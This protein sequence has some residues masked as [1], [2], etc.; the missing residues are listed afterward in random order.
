MSTARFLAVGHFSRRDAARISEAAA[1]AAGTAEF[2]SSVEDRRSWSS[3]YDLAGILLDAGTPGAEHVALESRAES[4]RMTLPILAVAERVSDLKFGEAFAWGADDL[5]QLD[6]RRGLVTRMRSLPREPL[7]VPE[8]K[9][10]HVLIADADRARRIAIGRV[11]RNAGYS[12][13]F[14]VATPDVA[15][16][17]AES[18]VTVVLLNTELEPEPK[19]LI[20]QAERSGSEAMWIVSCAPR[21]MR[22]Y[23]A[24]L[25][26]LRSATATDGFAPPENMLFV[27]NELCSSKRVEQRASARL[28][29]GT[30][31]WF[32]PAGHEE[33]DFGFCYN[34]SEGGLYVRTL[35]PPE[36]EQVWLELVPP[37]TERRVRLVGQVA[38]RR[39]FG[40]S[41]YATVPPGVG[42]Q[43]VDGAR[44]DLESWKAGYQAF[45]QDLS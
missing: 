30:T 6:Q 16:I 1:E 40:R 34:V 38:W 4:E 42:V 3:R 45:L 27:S 33:D 35:A 41:D 22:R 39:P 12:I 26:G 18:Q 43:I 5:V 28:L 24:M 8:A 10:G 36:G 17:V 2:V 15:R 20:E 44:A 23:R 37:R 31:V 7:P 11:L 13:S 19:T 32:R 9:R 25:A 29:Y 14:A 21:H